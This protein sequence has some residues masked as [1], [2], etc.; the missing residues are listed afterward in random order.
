MTRVRPNYREIL[1]LGSKRLS[2][3]DIASSVGASQKTV[4]KILRLAKERGIAWPLS[5]DQTNDELAKIFFLPVEQTATNRPMPNL[6]LVHKELMRNGVNK[7]LLWRE[8]IEHCRLSKQEPLMYSQFCYYIQQDEEKRRATMHIAHKP[9]ERIEVD[10]AGDPAHIID[11]VTGE[12]IN[13]SVFVGVLPYSQ[14]TFVEAFTN[15][16]QKAW[17]RAHVDM[18]QYF[19]G[20]STLLVPDNT[21]TAVV[22]NNNWYTPKLNTAYHE[23]AS[24]YDTVIIP[25]RVR[26]PKDKPSAEGNVG[27]VSTWIIAA[28]RDE[29]FFSLTELNE[30]IRDKL[31]A[32]NH[33]PFQ[34]KE[35][36]SYE[37]FLDEEKPYLAPLPAAPYP[38]AEWK[39]ATVQY[40][41]HIAVN[42]MMYSIPYEYIHKQVDVR[43]TDNAIEAFYNHT[44][45]ASHARLYGAKGQYSTKKEHMPEDHQKYLEWNGDRFRKWAKS[46]GINT[47]RVIDTILSSHPVE[48]QSYHSCMALLNLGKKFGISQLEEAC[49]QALSLSPSPSYKSVKNLLATMEL[50]QPQPK[51]NKPHGLTRGA[52]YFARR[53]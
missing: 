11:R 28:L 16:K 53:K 46:V 40:N 17:L 29:Q 14:Y 50:K 32:Y 41:Y 10:W 52:A 25:A 4:N 9:A 24:H 45:I 34:K 37:I 49:R 31:E 36:S 18:Y 1:R 38:L 33:R 5:E 43:I 12:I 30:A 23:L 7:K 47:Y 26:T 15:Q 42:G 2:Q 19:G 39:S 51:T 6:A 8:Y 21:K 44:R 20:V 35:G 3:Q 48:Q 13:V 22:H 27:H